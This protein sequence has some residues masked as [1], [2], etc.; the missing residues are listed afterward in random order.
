MKRTWAL[1]TAVLFLTGLTALAANA[2]SFSWTDTGTGISASGTLSATSIGGGEYVVDSGTGTLNGD[3]LVLIPGLDDGSLQT[4]PQ[5][6]F[7]FDNA[8]FP[9]SD[10]PL[11]TAGLLFSDTTT[12]GEFNIF[13]LGGTFTSVEAAGGAFTLFDDN[14]TF[15]LT[16]LAAPEP[17][18]SQLLVVGFMAL[19]AVLWRRKKSIAVA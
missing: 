3:S 4:S 15:T 2:D 9:G 12:G 14:S 7:G 5:G 17:G 6:Y 8:L 16:P 11:D 18:S 10:P 19:A 1:A 13:A